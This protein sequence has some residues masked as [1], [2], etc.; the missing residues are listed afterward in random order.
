MHLFSKKVLKHLSLFL[1]LMLLASSLLACQKQEESDKDASKPDN[2]M[3][4]AQ[5]ETKAAT[6]DS[7]ADIRMWTFLNPEATS[8]REVALKQIITNFQQKNPE[9]KVTV[10]PQQ[11]DVMTAKFFAAH[12][13]G[14]APDVQWV[15]QDEMGA[16]I[17]LN[18]LVPFEDLFMKSWTK[19]DTADVEDAFWSF[20]SADGKHYQVSLSRNYIALIYREDL[21]REKGINL[22]LK[23]WD[24]LIE[25]AKKLTEKD[26]KTGIQRWG[27]GIALN[28][29]KADP[30]IMPPAL[31]YEQ[32]SLFTADGKAQW[33]TEAGIKALNLQLDMIKKHKITP[34]SAVT[35]TPEDLYKDFNA[36][37]Y[38]MIVGAGV[39]VPKLKSE[40]TFEPNS[41]QMMHFPSY[42]GK[43]F[44]PAVISGWSV[45]VWSGS[46]FKEQAGKFVEF[47]FNKE[48]DT[49]WTVTGGQVPV[50]KS[51]IEAQKS[52]F[53]DPRNKYL[54]TM[55]EGFANSAYA[56]PFQFPIS[57]WRI[58]LNKAAQEVLVK[59][60][61][62]DEAL[63]GAEKEF[64][65]RNT[66]Q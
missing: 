47:M 8:S 23:T 64:N 58:D 44:S 19:E 4:A 17:K 6:A 22:P 10:E 28:L 2:T 59:G 55:A 37:K 15:L 20:G 39:R 13:A 24:E 45:G 62:A 16:A 33:S 46:K 56:Q 9:I 40:A 3:A 35:A 14:N 54:S 48:S 31:V 49:I 50:R 63:K 66:A 11:W 34:E 42:D 61:T 36:G 26:A 7:K 65:D 21:F 27:L 12:K 1:V 5:T 60:K 41:I 38:A 25:A 57:G 30:Q 18:T 32:G 51:T 53:E 43:G 52:F 29:D